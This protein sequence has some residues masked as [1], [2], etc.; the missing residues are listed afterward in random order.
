MSFPSPLCSPSIWL[1]IHFGERETLVFGG[2]SGKKPNSG[3]KRFKSEGFESW[4]SLVRGNRSPAAHL[5]INLD[6]PFYSTS[7][8]GYL[9][10]AVFFMIRPFKNWWKMESVIF[11]QLWI[12]TASITERYFDTRMCNYFCSLISWKHSFV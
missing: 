5:L 2:K 8:R 4:A 11:T 9:Q 7:N 1:R 12:Q 3:I 10:Y 6:Q